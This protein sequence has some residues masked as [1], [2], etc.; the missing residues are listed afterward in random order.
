MRTIDIKVSGMTCQHCINAVTE[1]LTALD[2]V[3]SVAVDLVTDGK[4][5]VHID[6]R[7]PVDAEQI[8]GAIDEAGYEVVEPEADDADVVSTDAPD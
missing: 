2:G 3:E 1:E 5:I 4:S 7:Q 6:T 8:A